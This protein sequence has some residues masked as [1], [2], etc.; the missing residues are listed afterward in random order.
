MRHLS[1]FFLV[2]L[3]SLTSCTTYQYVRLQ[4]DLPYKTDGNQF[5]FED[6]DL[7][8][9]YDFNGSGMP[10]FLYLE[11]TGSRDVYLDLSRSLFLEN[12]QIVRD[13]MLKESTTSIGTGPY[14]SWVEYGNRWRDKEVVMIPPGKI[15]KLKYRPYHV[16]FEKQKKSTA[17]ERAVKMPGANGNISYKQADYGSIRDFEIQ[18]LLA[19]N[20]DFENQ[21]TLS[22]HF[23][24]DLTFFTSSAPDEFLGGRNANVYH[25][26]ETKGQAWL[27]VLL[28]GFGTLL[29]LSVASM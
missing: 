19:N 1:P 13:L 28:V 4:S 3:L 20:R 25:T 10:V 16:G 18:L 17:V 27:P 15:L 26:Q 12:N 22:A 2:L 5:Y 24:P 8:V 23:K 7:F 21:W 11:N 6:D 9:A 29:L 14:G